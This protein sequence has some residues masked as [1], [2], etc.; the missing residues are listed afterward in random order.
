MTKMTGIVVGIMLSL[1]VLNPAGYIGRRRGDMLLEL[2]LFVGAMLSSLQG[3]IGKGVI[4]TSYGSCR[5]CSVVI[6]ML[7][8]LLLQDTPGGGGYGAAL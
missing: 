8:C 6:V 7:C 1:L 4:V 2:S 5:H 3:C